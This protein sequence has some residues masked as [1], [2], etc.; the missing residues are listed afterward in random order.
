MNKE[1]R[2]NFKEYLLEVAVTGI[3]LYM[4]LYFLEAPTLIVNFFERLKGEE[5]A[6]NDLIIKYVEAQKGHLLF[7]QILNFKRPQKY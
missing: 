3:S 2:E 4:I 5:V 7:N 6:I 1:T